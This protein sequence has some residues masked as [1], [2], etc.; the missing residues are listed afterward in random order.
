MTQTTDAVTRTYSEYFEAFQTL[1]PATVLPYFHLP[2][3]IVT[4]RSVTGV[5]SVTEGRALLATMMHGLK[6]SGYESSEW[7]NLWVKAL[8]EDTALL[9]VRVVRFKADDEV[10]EQFG[11]TY[12]FRL[13]DGAWRIRVLV[14]HD[15]D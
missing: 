1:N 6:A 13:S 9:S 11:A 8:R 12:L 4:P 10:L 3:T 15:P 2:F 7:S 14:I 5:A